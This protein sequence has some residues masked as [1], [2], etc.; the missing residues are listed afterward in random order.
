MS[1]KVSKALREKLRLSGVSSAIRDYERRF[2]THKRAGSESKE[3][4]QKQVN[5]LYYD[6]VTDFFEYGWGRPFHFAPRVPGESFK[7]SLVR[8][9]HNMS[10]ALELKPGMVVGGRRTEPYRH[11]AALK[12][13]PE[14][15]FQCL[16]T[17]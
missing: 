10:R 3:S 9:E 5:N 4:E 12:D 1:V 7:E 2:R 16:S 13:L 8:H 17:L 14:A 11:A 6:L 15:G